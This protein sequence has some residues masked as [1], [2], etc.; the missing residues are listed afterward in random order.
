MSILAPKT[1]LVDYF[2]CGG[3]SVV[4]TVASNTWGSRFE[5]QLKQIGKI[6]NL[7]IESFFTTA[8]LY[9]VSI[10]IKIVDI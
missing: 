10:T 9:L 4:R 2:G 3:S 6:N 7:H 1:K 8:L 5:S